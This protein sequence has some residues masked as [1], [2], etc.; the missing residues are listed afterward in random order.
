MAS[1]RA[2][3]IPKS[4]LP[5]SQ[6]RIPSASEGSKYNLTYY[7]KGALAGG[8]CCGLTH[9]TFEEMRCTIMLTL[10]ITLI[11]YAQPET[12]A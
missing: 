2:L 11:L 8:L 9:G 12:A 1:E 10:T 6:I 4:L 5:S 3:A 7:L